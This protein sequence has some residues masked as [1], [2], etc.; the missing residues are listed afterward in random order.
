MDRPGSKRAAFVETSIEIRE[1]ETRFR[2]IRLGWV[3]PM[4]IALT[5][6]AA[7]ILTLWSA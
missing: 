6:V 2:C 5:N 7:T 1:L 4:A 3:V